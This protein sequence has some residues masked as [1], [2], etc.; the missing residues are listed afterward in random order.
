MV[1]VIKFLLK[2]VF[3]FIAFC[4]V[5][6]VVKMFKIGLIAPNYR[7]TDFYCGI[8]TIA[9]FTI[10]LLSMWYEKT[11]NYIEVVCNIK[12]LQSQR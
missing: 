10:F 1:R 6:F 9:F 12:K 4:Q 5:C 3:L 8:G 2:T 11:I 7:V